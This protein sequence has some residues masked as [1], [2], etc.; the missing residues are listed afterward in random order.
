[1]SGL[2]SIG[3]IG[4]SYI[5]YPAAIVDFDPSGHLMKLSQMNKLYSRFKFLDF[6]QG[7]ILGKY[8]KTYGQKFD[9]ESSS[10]LME[11]N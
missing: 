8:F 11:L 5:S 4:G 9:P 3:A 1:M 10:T 6:R 7:R 2:D